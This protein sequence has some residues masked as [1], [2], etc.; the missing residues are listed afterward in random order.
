MNFPTTSNIII[1]EAD[2]IEGVPYKDI[3]LLHKFN[4]LHFPKISKKD[5]INYIYDEITDNKYNES[6]YLLNWKTYKDIEKLNLEKINKLL[7]DL[8]T[9]INNNKDLHNIDKNIETMI[10][11]LLLL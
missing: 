3:H 4:I 8:N 9:I 10:H 5:I 2:N 1:L 7:P 11:T 6:M